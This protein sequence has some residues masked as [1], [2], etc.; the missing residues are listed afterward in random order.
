MARTTV[1]AQAAH[2]AFGEPL[3]ERPK[4]LDTVAAASNI[5]TVMETSKMNTADVVKTL[6]DRMTALEIERT[7]LAECVGELERQLANARA[8]TERAATEAVHVE[9]LMVFYQNGNPIPRSAPEVTPDPA[10]HEARGRNQVGVVEVAETVPPVRR[11]PAAWSQ[12]W[13]DE[14]LAALR[15][16]GAPTHYRDLYKSI[17]ARGFTFGGRSPE[18][19]FL[20]SLNREAGIF[21]RVGRGSYWVAGEPVPEVGAPSESRRRSLRPRPIGHRR[22]AE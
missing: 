1:L 18:A 7:E 22:A 20:A 21:Q 5:A 19:T 2:K 17:A 6:V 12:A 11:A 10:S 16:R 14:T 4:S 3:P 9:A 15:D 8:A 13:R